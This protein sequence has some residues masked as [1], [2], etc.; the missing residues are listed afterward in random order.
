[1][2]NVNAL[3]LIKSMKGGLE[4]RLVINYR[5]FFV[6]LPNSTFNTNVEALNSSCIVSY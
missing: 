6:L 5:P 1:M 4:T 3:L 2:S